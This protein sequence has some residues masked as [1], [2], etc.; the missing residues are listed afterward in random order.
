VTTPESKNLQ[1]SVGTVETYRPE[2][3][4]S[5]TSNAR[6][7]AIEQVLLG[8]WR[9][10]LDIK[11]LRLD[12]DFFDLGGHSLIGVQLFSRIK[13][14]YGIDLGLSTL[15]EARTVH[16]LAKR[17]SEVSYKAASEPPAWSSLVAVQSKGSKPP[18]FW[19]PGAFGAS[20]L[21]F[22]E[23]S[24]LLGPDQPVYGFE[25]KMPEQNEELESV[26]ERASRFLS[27][28]RKLQPQ[29]PYSLIGF[30]SGGYIAYEM[31]QQLAAAGQTV[32]LLAMV[33]CYADHYPYT[34][35]GRLRRHIERTTWRTKNVLRRGPKGVALWITGQS[36]SLIASLRLR[37]SRLR[38]QLTNRPVPNLPSEPVDEY[39]KVR[40]TV[41]QY[42]LV[43]YPGK[44]VV[45]IGRDSYNFRGLS[46]AVDPRLV[47]CK[48]SKGGSEVRVIPG[49]HTELLEAPVMQRFAEELRSCL[50][51]SP[52][53]F[54]R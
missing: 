54:A 5:M 14:K 30:C 46:R 43:G 22:K 11:E 33:E 29:G 28:M 20:M 32:R 1:Y 41:D 53:G 21:A 17:I 39:A 50:E 45:I 26:S 49:D 47:W 19:L 38:A 9:E 37:A 23:I 44:S 18:V 34:R 52:S 13:G 6:E 27:E 42:S 8:W 25:A 7:W 15:F 4:E 3:T 10:L 16:E 24:L 31:A 48:L 40:R 36:K 12:D 35:L 2:T 51:L